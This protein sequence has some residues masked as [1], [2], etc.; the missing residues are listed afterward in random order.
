MRTALSSPYW[1][2]GVSVRETLD[3]WNMGPE[4]EI[5]LEGTWD[6]LARQEVTSYRDPLLPVDRH[7][8]IKHYLPPNFV[9]GW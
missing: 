3:R 6:Q 7:L 1:G 9:C 2:E 5:P 8:F 4:T